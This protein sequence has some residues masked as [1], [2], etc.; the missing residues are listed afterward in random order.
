MALERK[1]LNM[2]ID[3]LKVRNEILN[4]M[5]KLLLAVKRAEISAQFSQDYLLALHSDNSPAN[6]FLTR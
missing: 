1:K 4:V 6:C 5:L 2:N 3:N